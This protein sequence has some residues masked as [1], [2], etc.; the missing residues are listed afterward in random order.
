MLNIKE[1]KNRINEINIESKNIL[2]KEIPK[3]ELKLF[4]K[5]LK[6]CL[7]ELN[8]IVKGSRALNNYMKDSIYTKKELIYVDYDIFSYN[9]KKDLI[10]ITKQLELAG[11]THITCKVLPFKSD[12]SQ[13]HFYKNPIIDIEVITKKFLNKYKCKKINGIEYISP[14]LYK[15]DLYSILSQPTKI[16]MNV[17]EKAY[18]RLELLEKNYKYD[19]NLKDI[20]KDLLK[21]TLNKD[22]QE[23]IDYILSILNDNTIIIGNYVFNKLL[24]ENI[25][26]EYLELL[27]ENL[28]YYVNKLKSK[29]KNRIFIKE[30]K[31]IL[32]T[33]GNYNVLYL[34]RKPILILWDLR[35]NTSY[36][37]K[38]G[39]KLCS[40]YY[41][42]FYYNFLAFHNFINNIFH[43]RNYYY[44]LLSNIN[45]KLLPNKKSMGNVNYDTIE[46]Y[47]NIRT[48]KRKDFFSYNSYFNTYNENKLVKKK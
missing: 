10:Y 24:K 30:Y 38:D 20:N 44:Y 48:S 19:Y 26:I 17:Y 11:L 39:E 3:K 21:S 46:Q 16:N 7:K 15:I 45:T 28:D 4:H 34:D 32:Y 43:N 29:Y 12:I 47:N 31:K 5:I 6:R 13:L 14:E 37:I 8:V 9:Y 22:C 23:C 1:L 41:L 36:T 27:T 35:N 2:L 25:K 18:N 33:M 40:R 42:K